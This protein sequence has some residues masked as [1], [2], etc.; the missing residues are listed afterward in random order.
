[1]RRLV[2]LA[3][4]LSGCQLL[5]TSE[6]PCSETSRC[7]KLITAPFIIGQPD[8]KTNW[9]LTG[10]GRVGSVLMVPGKLLVADT[11]NS[12][13]LIWNSFPTQFN[14]APDQWLGEPDLSVLSYGVPDAQAVRGPTRMASDGNRLVV[15]T[16][17]G[18][19]AGRQLLFWNR[20]PTSSYAAFDFQMNASYGAPAGARTFDAAGPLLAGGRLYVTDRGYNR[21]LIWNSIPSTQ[22]DANLVIGQTNLTSSGA[23]AS[24]LSASSLSGPD[25][26]PATDGTSLFVSDA[27]NHR[28]LVYN[29]LPTANTPAASFALGQPNL[30]T[31]TA[32]TG[33]TSPAT[34][35]NPAGLAISGTRLAVA[36]RGNH[37][38]LLWNAIPTAGNTPADVVLGQP[39]GSSTSSNYGG[40]SGMSLSG[41]NSVA[42]D[43]TRIA[44]SDSNNNRV[45]LWNSWPTA[46]GTPA[47]LVLGQNSLSRNGSNGEFPGPQRLLRPSSITRA[48]SNFIVV[49]SD[50]NRVLIWS[51]FP[52]SST[53][54]PSL[55]LGQQDMM[56]SSANAGGVSAGTLYS[57]QSATSDGKVL[58]VADSSNNRVLIWNSIPTQNRQPADIVL[59]QPS[60]TTSD[61][62]PTGPTLGLNYPSAVHISGGRLYVA[63]TY[64]NRVL[65]W[66]S[67]PTQN[68][69][70][71][72]LVLGQ[73]DLTGFDYNHKK[74][75][76]DATTLGEPRGV[77]ADE[78]HIYVSDTDTNRVLIWNTLEPVNGQGADVVIGASN[79]TSYGKIYGAYSV[80]VFQGRLYLPDSGSSRI[81][82]WNSIPTQNGLPAASALGQPNLQSSI[83]NPG[84]LS[85]GVLQRPTSVLVTDIGVYVADNGNGRIVA[86]P[87]AP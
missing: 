26:P 69:Q 1:M 63:D 39:N 25:G 51:Q 45:L 12:R 37:R 43:G 42:T 78:S 62:N 30:T 23:N 7:A 29:P 65:V 68:Q 50:G 31:A 73:S 57:P 81:L 84:G 56:T 10:F 13:V 75:D 61:S 82:V 35:N 6:I 16:D 40:T 19:G 49:D 79:F 28:V 86:L 38:V 83:P 71:A 9:L 32:N 17:P 77:Y 5:P 74:A 2:N 8:E 53:A 58:V 4:L 20:F 47:D 3:V 36:D 18:S 11:S 87:P 60:T 66:K 52:L 64:N 67:I 80:Q 70:Q 24:G 55:V 22:A 34:L 33:G 59:G 15:A 27:Q 76:P 14:Q 54:Q 41:P 48:G 46:T 72:D 21:L 85:A 44:V